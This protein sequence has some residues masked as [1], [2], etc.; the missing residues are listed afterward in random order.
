MF[1]ING[2]ADAMSSLQLESGAAVKDGFWWSGYPQ[3]ILATFRHP[4]SSIF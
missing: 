3:T 4:T 1:R 2:V